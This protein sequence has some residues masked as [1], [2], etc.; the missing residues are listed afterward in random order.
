MAKCDEGYRCDVCGQDVTSIVDSD[1]YLRFVV[2][3]MDPER[4]HVAPERHLRCNPVLAQFIQDDRFEPVIVDG[5][6]SRRHLDPEPA[7]ERTDLITR[8]YARLHEIAAWPGDRDV[9][10]YPLPEVRSRYR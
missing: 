2:G 4:L 5:D 6:M 1:L 7:A 3:L 10:E 8:G 9:T